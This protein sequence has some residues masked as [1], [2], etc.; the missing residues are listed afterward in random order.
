MPLCC[1]FRH[2]S[3][4]DRGDNDKTFILPDENFTV[5]VVC[6]NLRLIRWHAAILC[7][8]RS[9]GTDGRLSFSC[10]SKLSLH[11]RSHEI[12]V[13]SLPVGSSMAWSPSENEIRDD[14]CVESFFTQPSCV[15]CGNQ[16]CPTSTVD[17]SSGPIL[18][19]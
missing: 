18:R 12:H 8:Y 14:W 4:I 3:F 19:T 2:K 17:D 11:N 7:A 5:G 15:F 16:T 10:A 13:L 6:R 1:R 9:V